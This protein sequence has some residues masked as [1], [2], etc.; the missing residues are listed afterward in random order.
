METVLERNQKYALCRCQEVRLKILE[1]ASLCF[2]L[3]LL[4]EYL[5]SNGSVWDFLQEVF[6][7]YFFVLASYS[8]I[9]LSPSLSF[10]IS[11]VTFP[12]TFYLVDA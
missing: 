9:I 1:Y 11:L 5:F 2:S 12:L 10:A 3:A 8:R 4:E 6:W 7:R